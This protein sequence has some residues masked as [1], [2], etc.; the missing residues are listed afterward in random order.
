MCRLHW[1]TEKNLNT[2]GMVWIKPCIFENVSPCRNSHRARPLLTI[3]NFLIHASNA[4]H[5]G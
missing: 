4:I 5:V 2:S 3:S 1:T